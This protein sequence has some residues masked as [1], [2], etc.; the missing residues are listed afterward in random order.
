[1]NCVFCKLDKGRIILES[2]NVIAIYDKYP[3]S[4][5]HILVI[6]REHKQSYFNL[7]VSIQNEVWSLVEKVREHLIIR[8]DPDGFN[9]GVNDGIPAGQTIP[10]CHI[11]VIPR[12]KGDIE[13]PAGGVRGVIPSK[14]KYHDT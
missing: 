13:N 4:Q 9:I 3:V 11:H 2:K 10:H 7:N 5:G 8:F 6:P 1:M 14:M 12:Y